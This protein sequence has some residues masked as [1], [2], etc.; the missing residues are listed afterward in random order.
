MIHM[1][2]ICD[3]HELFSKV[4]WQMESI[5]QNELLELQVHMEQS[6]Y[7]IGSILPKEADM[8][9]CS[10]AIRPRKK[11]F[12]SCNGLKKNTQA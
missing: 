11:K 7:Y 3:I 6:M 1:K 12:V 10:C 2:I 9:N 8:A 5:F 4:S